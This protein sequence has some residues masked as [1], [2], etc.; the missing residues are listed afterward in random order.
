MLATCASDGNISVFDVSK[1]DK[2]NK[3]SSF[4]A[5]KGPVW[6]ICWAHP[7]YGNILASCS[8]DRKVAVWLMDKN[9]EWREVTSHSE[10]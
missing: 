6:Q 2:P 7:R 8:F 5:H 3:I 1:K 4:K 10:H 9:N